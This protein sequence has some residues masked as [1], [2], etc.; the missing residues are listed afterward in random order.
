MQRH[1]SASGG[2]RV[3]GQELG[4]DG[5]S[6][7]PASPFASLRAAMSRSGRPPL[8]PSMRGMSKAWPH[9]IIV[10]LCA[11]TNDRPISQTGFEGV[12]GKEG[13]GWGGGYTSDSAL[14]DGSRAGQENAALKQK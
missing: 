11:G 3:G 5:Q 9:C 2:G 14:G 10:T 4:M 13:G 1:W 7:P 12:G 6:I 8:P